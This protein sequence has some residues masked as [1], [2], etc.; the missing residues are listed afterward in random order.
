[1]PFKDF[2]AEVEKQCGKQIKVVRTDRGE[3]YQ[4]RYTEDEQAPGPFAN[5]L[6][7]NGIVAQY[8]MSGSLDQ[9]GVAEIRNQ[10][11]MG[12]VRSMLRA[13]KLLKSLWTEA[14]KTTT[15]IEP[16][17]SQGCPKD[18]FQINQRLKIEFM[19]Y[20]RMGMPI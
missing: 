3:E 13:S 14:V 6:Q 12:M 17:S 20:M 11:L 18:T 15:Y 7:E 5:F 4:D 2:K 8:T 16:I 1:M 9:N 19:T 10:T